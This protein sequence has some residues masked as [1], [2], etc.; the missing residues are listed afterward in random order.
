MHYITLEEAMEQ[1]S[2]EKETEAL[3]IYKSMEQIG[4]QRYKRGRRYSSAL[5]LTLIILGK[6]VGMKSLAAIAQWARQEAGW[7][8]RILPGQPQKFPCAATYSNV[9][10]AV[11]AA[12]VTEVM[13]QLFCRLHAERARD[14]DEPQQAQEAKA[15]QHQHVALDGKTLRG[16]LGHEAVDQLPVHQVALY[17]TQT[18]IV[19]QEEVVGNKEN[20]LSV[21]S[22]FLDE[23]G[24]KGRI[25]TADALHTQTN[26]CWQVTRWQG[27][28]VLIAKGNQPTLSEDLRLFF[29]EPP[30][31]CL[32]WR[33]ASSVNKGHGRLETRVLTASRELNDFLAGTWIGVAQVF[34]IVRTI[35]DKKGIH[36]EIHYGL[37]SLSA[38]QAD[39][40]RL[41]EL[42]RAHWAIENRL[43]YRRDVTLGEDQSQVRKG[44]A[45]RALAV[46]NSVLL[47]CTDFLGVSNVAEQIRVFQSQPLLA[48]R[49]L[50]GSLLTFK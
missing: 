27:A 5:I 41:L 8:N 23:V 37:T 38:Q 32:D 45:P 39:A 18:G 14:S 1:V 47:A 43:H 40:A 31:D 42:V 21:V 6:L 35:Q 22:R 28:Y 2:W 34:R 11:D 9:L 7:L 29:C 13:S 3:T 24:V 25:I 33:E 48:A 15:D 50:L 36:Q 10:R 19:L 12:Q 46:L 26:F 49:A 44:T 17:E 16:T 4:D 30:L 20:E